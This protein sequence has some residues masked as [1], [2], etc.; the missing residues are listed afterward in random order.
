MGRKL[1]DG[2]KEVKVGLKN[3]IIPKDWDMVELNE[4]LDL[5]RNGT[6]EKQNK[7]GEGKPVTRIETIADGVVNY[8]KLGY[9]D[10]EKDLS[11]YN[12]KEGDI[13]F[14]HINSVK[15]IGKIAQYNGEQTLYHG[16]NLLLLRLDDSIIYPKFALYRLKSYEA[17]AFFESYAKKAVN[18]A[19]LNQTDVGLYSFPL[20]H[21]S[22]QKKIAD[23]LSSVDQAI[24]K[25]DEIIAKT[26][27]LK[28]G[29]MQELLTKGIG[30]DEFKEV[31]IGP[32]KIEVPTSWEFKTFEDVSNV[33]QG[34]QIAISDRYKEK[35]GDRYLYITV[36]HLNNPLDDRYLYYIENP[37]DSVI[38]NE[39]D[40]LM[41]RTGNTGEVITGVNGVFHNNFFM[42][43]YNDNIINKNFLFY[44]LNSKDIQHI[45]KIYAGTTT[46]PDL[47]HGDF[48]SIPVLLPPLEEQKKIANILSSVDNKI[49]KK[50]EQ[51]E[52]LEELK[53]GLMQKLLTGEVRVDVE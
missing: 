41:T 8:D 9:V 49:Q 37:R 4:V 32:K 47:N 12:L 51:K 48:Y 30:H 20:P 11:K 34:L 7:N 10:T 2:Y 50:Q 25:T 1:K 22:E 52:K 26:Q 27:E 53:K 35:K 18:Q 28:Q 43:D 24:E 16:M 31:R 3:R 39:D 40:I 46:I 36:Q 38:C 19:S 17:K 45:I 13:L 44:Y 42:I 33:R 21:Y 5:I 23:I 6:S 14:S 15:H 29:L